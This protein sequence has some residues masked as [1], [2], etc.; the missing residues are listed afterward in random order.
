MI[1]SLASRWALGCAAAIVAGALAAQA[2]VTITNADL[3]NQVGQYYLTYA[4]VNSTNSTVDVSS[5]L[6]TASSTAQAWDFSTGPQAVTNRY[7]Y[8]AA[9]ST[10]YGADFVAVG[11]K[12]AQQ[13]AQ[14]GST[15]ALQWLYFTVDPVKGQ[16]DYGFYSP[17]F[18][19]LQPESV[20]TNALQDFP[21]SIRYGDSWSGTTVFYSTESLASVGT[22]SAIVT[23]TTTDTVDAFGY[24]TL[25][26]LGILQCLR[27]HELAEYDIGLNLE[28]L[29]LLPAGTDYVLNYYWLAP[30]HGMVAQINSAESASGP[31]P[32]DLGGQAANFERMFVAYHP[33]TNSTPTATSIS[34]FKITLLSG[35]AF[36]QWTSLAGVSSYTVEYATSLNGTINWQSL[37]ST[38]SNFMLDPA[39]TTP[40]APVRYYRVLGVVGVK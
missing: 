31:P 24:V 40:S 25:P 12:V 30:G 7:D 17:A 6:G 32:D 27:V 8:V 22:F 29:G 9:A 39:A 4:N 33:T 38:A 37:G 13:L 2:Q 15:N 34:G 19:S 23:N 28:G 36:L 3:F 14:E 5:V 1:T 16:L 11:A 20:F 10:P 35:A 26:G 18:S 21:A